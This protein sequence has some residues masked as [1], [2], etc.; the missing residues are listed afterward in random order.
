MPEM[1]RAILEPSSPKK[2]TTGWD[3]DELVSRY[4]PRAGGKLGL[5]VAEGRSPR[6]AV[7]GTITQNTSSANSLLLPIRAR[8]F[9]ALQR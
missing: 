8:M 4:Q 5:V 9:L 1:A 7:D 2:S 3:I 6:L